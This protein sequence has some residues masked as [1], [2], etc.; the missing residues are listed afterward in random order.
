[1]MFVRVRT[2]PYATNI[3]PISRKQLKKVIEELSGLISVP[4]FLLSP[5]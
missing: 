3:A 2:G 1:M 5:Q 4:M